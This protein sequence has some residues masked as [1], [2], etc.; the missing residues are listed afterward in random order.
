[1]DDKTVPLDVL[2]RA[3]AKVSTEDADGTISLDDVVTIAEGAMIEKTKLLDAIAKEKQYHIPVR[4]TLGQIA[5]WGFKYLPVLTYAT[6]A[7]LLQED[8][9]GEHNSGYGTIMGGL[10]AMGEGAILTMIYASTNL[11]PLT[12]KILLGTIIATQTVSTLGELFNY[13]RNHVAAERQEE[14]RAS[15][16]PVDPS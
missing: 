12:S 11:S 3:L 10:G 16:N 2:E 7:R 13:A 6:S 4:E 5:E 1:M 9:E 15:L 14:Y 8:M